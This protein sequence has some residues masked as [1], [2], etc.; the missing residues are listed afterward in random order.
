[1]LDLRAC[2]LVEDFQQ[3]CGLLARLVGDSSQGGDAGGGLRPVDDPEEPAGDAEADALGLGDGGE[4][5]SLLRG[6]LDG[7]I[8][9]IPEDLDLD[10]SLIELVTKV[11]DLGPD[12]LAIDGLD[13]LLGLAIKRLSRLVAAPGHLG[14]IAVS[15][16]EDR[17]A[18][19]DKLGDRGHEI[20]SGEVNRRTTPRLHTPGRELSTF[21]H[22]RDADLRKSRKFF[23]LPSSIL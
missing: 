3:A 10:L 13:D 12:G 1:M 6:D 11:V 22:H 2:R 19:G 5:V 15:T 4:L 8:Q 7:M 20:V 21:D 14:H 17:E 23:T 9:A 18:A 16:T